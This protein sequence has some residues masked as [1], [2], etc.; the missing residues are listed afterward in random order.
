MHLGSQL[1][2]CSGCNFND[3]QSK[4]I[5]E[6]AEDTGLNI[7][8]LIQLQGDYNNIRRNLALVF[9]TLNSDNRKFFI[10]RKHSSIS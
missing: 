7:L 2:F 6:K 10:E 9:L 3:H 5:N 4:L 8:W 1:V